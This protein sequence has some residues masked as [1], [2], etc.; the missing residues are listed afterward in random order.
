M[1]I[2][3]MNH[4]HK[5]IFNNDDHLELFYDDYGLE[6]DEQSFAIQNMSTRENCS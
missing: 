3:W 1:I 4:N 5:V 6:P 2:N